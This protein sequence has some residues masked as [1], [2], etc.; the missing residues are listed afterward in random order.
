MRVETREPR[1]LKAGD[2]NVSVMVV[3]S[4]KVMVVKIMLISSQY[5][6]RGKA[7]DL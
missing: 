2:V 5:L 3:P 4:G 7:T 1:S 6:G